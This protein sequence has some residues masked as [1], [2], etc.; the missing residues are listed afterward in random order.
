MGFSHLISFH[1]RKCEC[2]YHINT[3]SETR[4]LKIKKWFGSS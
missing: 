3:V 4:I 2:K 1:S